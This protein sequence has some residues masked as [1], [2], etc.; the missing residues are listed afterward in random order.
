M[1]TFLMLSL[2]GCPG[3]VKEDDKTPSHSLAETADPYIMVFS[4]DTAQGINLKVTGG[5]PFTGQALSPK[6]GDSINA[7][8]PYEYVLFNTLDVGIYTGP[9]GGGQSLGDTTLKMVTDG[10]GTYPLDSQNKIKLT[11]NKDKSKYGPTPWDNRNWFDI[12]YNGVAAPTVITNDG[13]T[14]GMGNSSSQAVSG[15]SFWVIDYGSENGRWTAKDGAIYQSTAKLSAENVGSRAYPVLLTKSDTDWTYTAGKTGVA[16]DGLWQIDIKVGSNGKSD[17]LFC[18]TF[19]LAERS[20]LK[21]GTAGYLDDSPGGGSG[22]YGREI[23][24]METKWNGG[25][26]TETGP[27]LNLPNGNSDKA[28]QMSWNPTATQY[29]NHMPATWASNGGAPATEFSTFGALIRNDTLWIYGYKTDGTIWY[30]TDAIPMNNPEYKQKAPFAPYI[31]TWSSQHD[32]AGG[33]E[34]GYANFIYL[35]ADDPKIA[36]KNPKDNPEAFGK[37]LK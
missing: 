1:N 35:S 20:D 15:E 33:F 30:S 7:G 25:S 28:T 18:E 19:Y 3:T 21:S 37:A 24:I 16:M 27:Q 13:W 29:V 8:Y 23:D 26:S 34:T 12:S 2:L 10:G 22:G 31:G 4:I 32:Q 11:Y 17:S 5:E 6:A 9:D 14:S 36:G